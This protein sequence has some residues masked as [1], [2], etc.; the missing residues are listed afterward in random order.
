LT[1]NSSKVVKWL[2]LAGCRAQE[3]FPVVSL[4]PG[5]VQDTLDGGEG[6]PSPMLSI[7]GLLLKNLEPHIKNANAHLPE[8]LKLMLSLH[9]G[10]K[11]F[12]ATG[13]LMPSVRS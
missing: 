12:V 7:T 3:I 8:N 10:S 2:L 13:R 9:N 1:D 6:L 5:I 11:A 4:E